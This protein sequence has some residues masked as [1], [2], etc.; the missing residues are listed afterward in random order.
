MYLGSADYVKL[1]LSSKFSTQIARTCFLGEKSANHVA[2]NVTTDK[3]WQQAPNPINL[4]RLSTKIMVAIHDAL[5]CGS[6]AL[7]RF[8]P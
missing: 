8:N 4:I 3:I 2:E 6:L 5:V 7:I 1:A